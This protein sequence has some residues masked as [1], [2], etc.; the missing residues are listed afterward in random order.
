MSDSS[1]PQVLSDTELRERIEWLAGDE[2]KDWV[3]DTMK[4]I[5]EQKIA[6]AEYVIGDDIQHSEGC[7]LS[8]KNYK[9]PEN[10]CLCN[11]RGYNY[12]RSEQR[13]RNV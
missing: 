7:K 5:N 8:K 9:K 13:K 12:L 6:H 10:I 1:K 4:L 11:A 3:E 2:A